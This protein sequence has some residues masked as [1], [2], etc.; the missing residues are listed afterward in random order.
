MTALFRHRQTVVYLALVAATCVSFALGSSHGLEG[1]G[2]EV[3]TAVVLA[4]AFVKVRYVGLDFMEL[5]EA[6]TP[7]RVAFELWVAGVGAAVVWFSRRSGR[8]G[9]RA[10]AVEA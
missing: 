10:D 4:I 7:L 6:A 2:V 3:A 9:R 1:G 5:R 8:A